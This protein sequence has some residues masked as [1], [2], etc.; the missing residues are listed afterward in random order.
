MAAVTVNTSLPM[1]SFNCA[2]TCPDS[3]AIINTVCCQPGVPKTVSTSVAFSCTNSSGT[4]VG[5]NTISPGGEVK[6]S[7]TYNEPNFFIVGGSPWPW[8]TS[9]TMNTDASMRYE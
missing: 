6:A 3:D 1:A 5:C 8:P 4:T 7:I 2:R 9:V